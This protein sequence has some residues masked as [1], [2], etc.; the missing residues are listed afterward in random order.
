MIL[1]PIFIAVYIFSVFVTRYLTVKYFKTVKISDLLIILIPVLN[2]LMVISKSVF[3]LFIFSK[4]KIIKFIRWF[5][6]DRT[7]F[8]GK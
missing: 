4:T 8:L 6:K 7:L 1:I 3:N 5:M 2:T